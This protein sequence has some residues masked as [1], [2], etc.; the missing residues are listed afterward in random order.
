M[1]T[2]IRTLPMYAWLALFAACN[3]LLPAALTSLQHQS[4]GSALIS[5]FNQS[6]VIWFAI[7]CCIYLCIQ[8][9]RLDTQYTANVK[10][11]KVIYSTVIICALL[12]MIP[13]ALLGWIICAFSAL[14]WWLQHPK[15][16]HQRAA[17]ILLL[18]TA[19]R[20][21]LTF[22]TLN[23]LS[24][25]ILAFDSLMTTVILNLFNTQNSVLSNIIQTENFSL[26]IL[27]G[28]SAFK[29][30]SLALLFWLALCMTLHQSTQRQDI[31]RICLLII[32]V[33][34]T[35]AIRLS[36]MTVSASYYDFY[37]EGYG[38]DIFNT[39]ILLMPLTCIPWRRE[40]EKPHE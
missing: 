14:L 40:N 8:G 5:G 10:A 9:F 36:L 4:F 24:N 21:P 34:L 26:L 33:L 27:T 13:S 6:L 3:A 15:S 1:N 11:S 39:T 25:Q 12:L 22:L 17:A 16:P 2:L 23:L 32:L 31:T 38:A 29:N 30:I 28:C 19:L 20:E 37:H 18:A 35:N 7:A